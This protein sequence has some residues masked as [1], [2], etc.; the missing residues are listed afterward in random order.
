ME[1][2]WDAPDKFVCMNCVEDDYLRGVIEGSERLGR[3]CDYCGGNSSAPLSAM[4]EPVGA[5]LDCYFGEPGAMSVPRYE[6]EWLVR[7][8]DT[9]LALMS[10]P[11]LCNEDLFQ[12]VVDAFH[13]DQWVPCNGYW[14]TEHISDHLTDAWEHFEEVAKHRT[15]YFLGLGDIISASEPWETYPDP[16]S[17]LGSVGKA[18]TDLGL[19]RTIKSQHAVYRARHAQKDQVFETLDALG[20]PPK[21]TTSAGRMNPAGISYL[22]LAKERSTAVGEVVSR[23]PCRISIGKFQLKRDIVV[24]DLTDIPS[25]PS[26]FDFDNYER[27]Q[28]ILFL[29]EFVRRISAPVEKDQTS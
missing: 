25:P 16:V 6:D 15:R 29:S 24:L 9:F 10:L 1:R 22:Y 4:L 2:G 8:I 13:N 26:V 17:L 5:A 11:L 23:P 28:S 27:R 14:S 3:V 7:P 18:A 19:I 12:D 21:G 20:P